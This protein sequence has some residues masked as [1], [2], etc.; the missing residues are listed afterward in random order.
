MK[1]TTIKLEVEWTLES[2]HQISPEEAE[3]I[4]AKHLHINNNREIILDG[5]PI[6]IKSKV[7]FNI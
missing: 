4:V 7:P 5:V 2:E 1:T 3:V 6:Q